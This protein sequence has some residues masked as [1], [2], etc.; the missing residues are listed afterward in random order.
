MRANEMRNAQHDQELQ[1][2]AAGAQSR[3]QRRALGVERPMHQCAKMH[4]PS[5]KDPRADRKLV[6]D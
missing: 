3:R 2:A 5:G 6:V 1:Q 4:P